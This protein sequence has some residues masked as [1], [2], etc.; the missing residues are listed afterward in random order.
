M[1][2]EKR[3][4]NMTLAECEAAYA[5][6]LRAFNKCKGLWAR[7][8]AAARLR[9][10]GLRNTIRIGAIQPELLYM[11]QG[12]DKGKRGQSERRSRSRSRSAADVAATA[13]PDDLDTWPGEADPDD[14]DDPDDLDDLDDTQQ[15]Q[16][17]E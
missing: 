3:A 13:D 16:E 9:I 6:M 10:E 14:P 2:P 17:K 4:D 5:D 8:I 15:R 11:L 7:D 1:P 12:R